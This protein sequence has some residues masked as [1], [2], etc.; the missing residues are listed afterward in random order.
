M[1]I[2]AYQKLNFSFRGCRCLSKSR[3]KTERKESD[4]NLFR[5]CLRSEKKIKTY[6]VILDNIGAFGRISGKRM[7]E[8]EIYWIIETTQTTVLLKAARILKRVLENCEDIVKTC[9]LHWNAPVGTNNI[10]SLPEKRKYVE[11]DDR[12]W[13]FLRALGKIWV[14]K[15]EEEKLFRKAH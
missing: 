9:S 7:E 15:L 8:M 13:P 6:S 2:I 14:E 12:M 5:P 3:I 10:L 4:L 11:Y 1:L